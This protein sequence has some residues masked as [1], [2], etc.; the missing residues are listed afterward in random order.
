MSGTDGSESQAAARGGTHIT[1]IWRRTQ[2]AGKAVRAAQISGSGAGPPGAPPAE[3]GNRRYW[4]AMDPIYRRILPA[5]RPKG[6]VNE[7]RLSIDSA[8]TTPRSRAP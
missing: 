4:L 1:P 6:L 5:S 3:I 8:G 2:P 7:V